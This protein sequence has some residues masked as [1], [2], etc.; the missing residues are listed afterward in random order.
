MHYWLF[1][2]TRTVNLAVEPGVHEKARRGD[3]VY[4][5]EDSGAVALWGVVLH[6][7][8]A[9]PDG[10]TLRVRCLRAR[11]Q[12][13]PRKVRA[14]L[15]GDLPDS[16]CEVS[17]GGAEELA[18]IVGREPRTLLETLGDAMPDWEQIQVPDWERI[19][20]LSSR[21]LQKSAPQPDSAADKAAAKTSEP[22]RAWVVAPAL[23]LEQSVSARNYRRIEPGARV[24]WQR[25]ATAAAEWGTVLA[26]RKWGA[27]RQ[28]YRVVVTRLPLAEAID[29][30]LVP[31]EEPDA[32]AAS[33]EAASP[34]AG[35]VSPASPDTDSP[36]RLPARERLLSEAEAH[37]LRQ[38]T[39]RMP[40]SFEEAFREELEV[41]AGLRHRRRYHAHRSPEPVVYHQAHRAQLAGLAFSGGGI[42]SATFNLGVLQALA[43]R[44]LL[45]AFDYLSTV[46]G[47]GYVGSWLVAWIKRR[48]LDEVQEQ[49]RRE[50]P[51]VVRNRHLAAAER[52]VPLTPI[53]FLRRYSNFLTPRLGLFGADSWT[54]VAT[55][56]RNLLL[57]LLVLVAALSAL[58]LVP[59]VVV[60]VSSLLRSPDGGIWALAVTLV[61][62]AIGLYYLFK[63]ILSLS[64]FL[65]ADGRL[66]AGE[67][68]GPPPMGTGAVQ[69]RVMLPLLVAA[70][71]G[72][73]AIWSWK[74]PAAK[75]LAVRQWDVWL[76]R[77]LEPGPLAE[78]ARLLRGLDE[79]VL[80][81]LGSAVLY[82]LL[83][84]PVALA[85]AL[86]FLY[87]RRRD[88]LKGAFRIDALR[89]S[90]NASAL[91]GM[92]F[93]AGLGG[94]VLLWWLSGELYRLSAGGGGPIPIP[95]LHG[96]VAVF[97]L[98]QNGFPLLVFWGPPAMVLVMVVT[99]ALHV[100]LMGR[101]FAEDHRQWW[102]RLG[103]WM[104]IAAMSWIGLF[105]IAIYGPVVLEWLARQGTAAV[106][107][108]SLGWVGSTLAG[109]WAARSAGTAEGRPGWLDLLARMT[110]YLFVV[111]LLALLAKAI[112]ATIAAVLGHSAAA[113]GT[114]VR[115][116]LAMTWELPNAGLIGLA[117]A[118]TGLALVALW[119]SYRID[120][121][122]FSMH[123]FY[124]NRLVRAY[125]GASRQRRPHPFTGF[126]REDDLDL[127]AILQTPEKGGDGGGAAGVV[128]D[129][130]VYDG[131][132]PILNTALN[133]SAGGDLAQQERKASSFFFTPL[134]YGF[135]TG[136]EP[137]KES[138][139]SRLLLENEPFAV[140]YTAAANRG[141]GISLGTAMTV[142]GAAVSPNM[143]YHSSPPLAFLLTVFNAR[144][145][146]WLGNPRRNATW[147][148]AGPS[149]GLIYLLAELFG[150]TREDSRYV[151]LADG[152]F[153]DNLGIYELVRRRC[154]YIVACDAEADPK[155]EFGGLANAVRKCRTDFGVEIEIDV[156]PIRVGAGGFSGRHCAVGK[157]H[158]P[159]ERARP[160]VLVYIKASLTGD[161]PEDLMGYH[162]AH[163]GFPHQ[164]TGDQWFDE[165]QFESYRAL[166]RHAAGEVFDA[167]DLEAARGP[168]GQLGLESVFVDLRQAWYQPSQAIQQS[169][170]QHTSL[171]VE[172][173]ERLRSEE[174]L[175]YL[176]PQ[177]YREFAE[178]RHG[179]PLADDSEAAGDRGEAAASYP[180]S[181]EELS[182]NEFQEGFFLCNSVI[183]LMENV[184]LDL[185]LESEWNHPD[186]RG[187]MNLFRH[188]SWSWMFRLTWAV[189]AATYGARFQKFCERRLSIPSG[190]VDAPLRPGPPFAEP[191]ETLSALELD[192]VRR[193]GEA[194]RLAPG[195]RLITLPL[196]LAVLEP[197]SSYR[198]ALETAAPGDRP[199]LDVLFRFTFGFAVILDVKAPAGGKPGRH[200]LFLRV[201]DHLR[202]LG[203]GRRAVRY[204]MTRH[205]LDSRPPEL[206]DD[207]LEELLPDYRKDDVRDLL[208]SVWTELEFERYSGADAD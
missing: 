123:L 96:G 6:G 50:H 202:K 125:L 80:W 143:G 207:R 187:W 196:R 191:P 132:L 155:L 44:R 183:Q 20:Q 107:T 2:R 116:H 34:G 174:N 79:W 137:A 52:R 12:V 112:Q 62:L 104:L 90:W 49:L 198:T 101:G 149:I 141:R 188:W 203:L 26:K 40:S 19:K 7:E 95:G 99:A 146:L 176:V 157:I 129:G 106:G 16:I 195:S 74:S 93:V 139:R 119:L 65:S 27:R 94:G 18:R 189:S 199:P 8:P 59:R 42:R 108:I 43:E 150:Q 84:L 37:R 114:I 39:N 111:G 159:D 153:F 113:S 206:R 102:S 131:P 73:C 29:L 41:V 76:L 83:W 33:P 144:L 82:L 186:N 105:A 134:H 66:G 160:G 57:N 193:V 165:S 118:A 53:T 194:C 148:M 127:A 100:G 61:A 69:L 30:P 201:R 103:A 163:S 200:L 36:P 22:P 152:G 128:A 151:S 147:E 63:N 173:F 156:E 78:L 179:R 54:V 35:A 145:G 154:R 88:W 133:L 81:V 192:L 92:A 190:A 164:S 158:Y 117:A 14:L 185:D 110:P 1:P 178:W 130:R 135:D 21:V 91:W 77:G 45:P 204:L 138:D 32:S 172:I 208:L 168:N 28:Q 87:G 97:S 205:G 169:F 121:N 142:S 70:W 23:R 184:Y 109:I 11:T 68:Y 64:D 89:G 120:I 3:R 166:G 47:G 58:L 17:R 85:Q 4:F 175:S 51:K 75:F 197:G 13:S 182:P 67:A 56:S 170:T 177:V 24:L 31:P 9:H 25:D 122:E 115:G 171:L 48:G 180:G 46:S 10:N 167:A 136:V 140:R 38:V 5:L 161:E 15:G 71:V 72:S 126:D 55:Y 86:G 98:A 124:R 162:K 181:P 60:G